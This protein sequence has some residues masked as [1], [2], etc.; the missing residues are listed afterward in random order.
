MDAVN[1]NASP[2][3]FAD[4]SNVR[5]SFIALFTFWIVWALLLIA[6]H[7]LGFI[8]NDETT[9]ATAANSEKPRR[10][11]GTRSNVT[12]AQKVAR[13]VFITML[14]MIVASTLGFGLTHGSMV[15]VWIYFAVGLVWVLVD[16]V[17]VHRLIDAAFGV[18]E[19]T[20]ALAVM[21]IGFSKGW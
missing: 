16:M 1:P 6:D 2:F 9:T 4:N 10:F 8:G 21:G 19:F 5:R 3:I 14:W 7:G 11:N 17:V 13:N 18:V 12:R 15:L 20:L